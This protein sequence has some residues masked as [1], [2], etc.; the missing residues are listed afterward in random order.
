MTDVG[1]VWYLKI[2]NGMVGAICE[3]G[4]AH[5]QYGHSTWDRFEVPRM[6]DAVTENGVLDELF[7]A[8]TAALER[9]SHLG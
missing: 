5:L 9:R 4:T 2:T 8:L 6:P 7:M 1:R 3:V